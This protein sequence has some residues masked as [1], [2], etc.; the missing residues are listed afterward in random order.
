LP[1]I[2]Y[3]SNFVSSITAPPKSVGYI[4]PINNKGDIDMKNADTPA[5]ACEFNIFSQY[6]REA[7][8]GLTKREMMAMQMMAA[9]ITHHGSANNYG[10][11]PEAAAQDAV[12]CAD[13]LL[14]EL[15]RT[16]ETK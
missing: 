10:F 3:H 15:E 1:K 13:A 11:L 4:K 14:A 9:W 6:A 16:G 5:T 8:H 12:E 7:H 2:T